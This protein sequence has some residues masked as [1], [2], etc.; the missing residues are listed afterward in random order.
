[1]KILKKYGIENININTDSDKITTEYDKNIVESYRADRSNSIYN[2]N[3]IIIEKNIE[4][5]IYDNYEKMCYF[6]VKYYRS[7][8]LTNISYTPYYLNCF[9]PNINIIYEIS[10][11]RNIYF[12]MVDIYF[13]QNYILYCNCQDSNLIDTITYIPRKII[14]KLINDKKII[15]KKNKE[16]LNLEYIKEINIKNYNNIQKKID[17]ILQYMKKYMI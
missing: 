1:M 6:A 16:I 9:Y 14:I 17:I 8:I 3:N 10:N 12:T 4:V 15:I 13:R 7:K 5:N 2:K 11:Y